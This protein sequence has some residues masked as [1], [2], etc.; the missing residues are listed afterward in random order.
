MAGLV[1]RIALGQIGPLC[2]SPQDSHDAVGHLP[3]AAPRPL[4]PVRTAG[5]LANER[6]QYRP[7]LV[8]YVQCRSLLPWRKLIVGCC[9]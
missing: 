4:T 1:R 9:S 6:L 3:A 2:A 8:G 5:H 7:L